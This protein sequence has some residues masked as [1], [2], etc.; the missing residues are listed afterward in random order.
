MR[1]RYPEGGLLCGKKLVEARVLDLRML[2]LGNGLD[3]YM[4]EMEGCAMGNFGSGGRFLQFR[5]LWK[6]LFWM[7]RLSAL[8]HEGRV[9]ECG[10]FIIAFVV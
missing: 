1:A 6:W 2:R 4:Y 5:W 9:R 7:R 8:G 3:L 10:I